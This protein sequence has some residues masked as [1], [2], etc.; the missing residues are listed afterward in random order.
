MHIHPAVNYVID[1]YVIINDVIEHRCC[2]V[3]EFD[4]DTAILAIYCY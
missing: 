1:S 3:M 2:L 4:S